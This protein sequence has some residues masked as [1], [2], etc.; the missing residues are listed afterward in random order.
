MNANFPIDA[1]LWSSEVSNT[2]LRL[3]IK[4]YKDL[5]QP[6][7][8]NQ[9]LEFWVPVESRSRKYNLDRIKLGSLQGQHGSL[10]ICCNTEQVC[11]HRFKSQLFCLPSILRGWP[12]YITSLW[13]IPHLWL[14]N[15][16]NYLVR[17]FWE[18]V[19]SRNIY[20]VSTMY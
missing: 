13:Y 11:V 12:H 15:N 10:K 14:E 20:W 9:S 17:L 18:L 7:Y 1:T 4:T 5:Q 19:D 3:Q 16:D 6:L 2:L 8:C